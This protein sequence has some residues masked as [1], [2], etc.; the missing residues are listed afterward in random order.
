VDVRPDE[1]QGTVV[2]LVLGSCGPTLARNVR[3]VIDPTLALRYE[4]GMAGHA[5]PLTPLVEA[6]LR[7][8]IGVLAP[9]RQV[10]WRLGLGFELFK[11][12][13]ADYRHRVTVAAD[14]P[15]GPVAPLV[16]ELDLGLIR[17]SNDAPSGSLHLVRKAIEGAATT[18]SAAV[19]IAG[20]DR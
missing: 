16:Y 11:D 5:K 12:P 19:R 4:E 8:G 7:D 3:V 13:G 9:G 1:A 10:R 17:E 14:G 6:R 18:L 20:G 15:S 2:D